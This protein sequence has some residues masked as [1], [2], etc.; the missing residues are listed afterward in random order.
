MV[1]A[2][3]K[4]GKLGVIVGAV[5]CETQLRVEISGA[6]NVLNAEI[7]PDF[8]CFHPGGFLND[9]YDGR[10]CFFNRITFEQQFALMRVTGAIFFYP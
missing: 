8:F 10:T 2:K 6:A 1:V 7:G 5:G 4:A 3:Q 9:M